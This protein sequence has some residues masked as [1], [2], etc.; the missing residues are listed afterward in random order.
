MNLF[1]TTYGIEKLSI[2]D[3]NDENFAYDSFPSIVTGKLNFVV[4][5]FE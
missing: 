5:K 4:N 2:T 3:G 1:H